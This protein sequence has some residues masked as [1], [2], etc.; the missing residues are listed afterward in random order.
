MPITATLYCYSAVK[1][2]CNLVKWALPPGWMI[3]HSA[4]RIARHAHYCRNWISTTAEGI[5]PKA[6]AHPAE[7]AEA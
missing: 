2:L 4:E 3:L 5:P 1:H 7:S 6:C